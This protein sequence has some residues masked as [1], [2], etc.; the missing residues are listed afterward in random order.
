[1]SLLNINIVVV[2]CYF[3]GTIQRQYVKKQ[4][5]SQIPHCI[6]HNHFMSIMLPMQVINMVLILII[7]FNFL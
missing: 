6:I 5:R 7:L 3:N 2:H 4:Q 1:M